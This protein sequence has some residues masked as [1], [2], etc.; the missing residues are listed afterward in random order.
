MTIPD[1]L[2]QYRQEMQEE[3]KQLLAYWQHYTIDEVHGGFAGQVDAN[4][5]I[6]PFAPKGA[7]L[8]ARILWSFAAAY[9]L[10]KEESYL[11]TADRALDYLLTHFIDMQHGGV[12]WSL[13]YKGQILD[14]KKQ[15]YAI[16]F[17]IYA[18]SE[19]YRCYQNDSIKEKA[20]EMYNV[21]VRRTYDKEHGG[22]KEAFTQD[23]QP[24]AEQRLSEKDDNTPKSM[25]THLHV[26]EAFTN[27]YR[28]WPNENLGWHIE[29]L[30]D[31]FENHIINQQTHTLHLF[32]EMDW[33]VKGDTISFGHD[34]EAAWLL[35]EAAE[36]LG[37]E[38]IIE[39][40]KQTAV[41]IAT[42][43]V[44]GLDD[45]GGLW[46]ESSGDGSHWVL[47]KHSWPQAEAMVGFFNAW[48]LTGDEKWLRHSVDSWHFAKQYLK[49]P[50]GEWYWGI[51]KD[52]S[53]M[54]K[55]KAGFWKCP[56]HTTRACMEIIK[57]IG[58][59]QKF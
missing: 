34:I 4:N 48:Q 36:V 3:L 24:I 8:N 5:I 43:A 15:V 12:Y 23:W 11:N 46:Y 58:K 7:V 52:G 59:L 33:T 26:L 21:L 42:A 30:M 55:D 25:N 41:T 10:T 28:I 17:A 51:Y 53:L 47:E 49:D 16:A 40:T 1:Q 39:R 32:F 18:L 27:L 19:Y 35:L 31:D 22:F 45:D 37:D 50:A 44:K 20:I 57:R 13:D 54:Q 29:E 14:S 38:S 6:H 9:R 56:Y 2:Q